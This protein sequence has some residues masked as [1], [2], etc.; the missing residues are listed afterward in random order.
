MPCD[1]GSADIGAW[2]ELWRKGAKDPFANHARGEVVMLDC[3]GW[4]LWSDGPSISAIGVSE[5]II[6]AS[7]GHVMVLPKARAQDVKK[8]VEQ[9]KARS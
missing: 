7:E 9:W 5:M 1:T 2:S 8:I 3:N 4:L 6:V